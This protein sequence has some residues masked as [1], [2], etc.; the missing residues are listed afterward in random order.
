MTHDGPVSGATIADS[1]HPAAQV[2]AIAS[3][4]SSRADRSSTS[5]GVSRSTVTVD[6]DTPMLVLDLSALDDEPLAI[7][8]TCAAGWVESAIVA[9]ETGPSWVIY[10]EAWR[11]LRLE[12]LVRRMQAQWK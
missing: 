2:M 6:R 12:P 8:M 5:I 1:T 4:S 7:A 10:D 11:V 3:G 9:P